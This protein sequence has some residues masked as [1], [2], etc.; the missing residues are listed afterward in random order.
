MDET[1]LIK[2]NKTDL[3]ENTSN[4]DE[5]APSR[6]ASFRIWQKD[7]IKRFIT[8][9][10]VMTIKT[11][12]AFGLIGILISLAPVLIFSLWYVNNMR[13]IMDKIILED[14]GIAQTAEDI[15]YNM[16]LVRRAEKNYLLLKDE[17]YLEENQNKLAEVD[18]LTMKIEELSPSDNEQVRKLSNAAI[19]YRAAFDSLVVRTRTQDIAKYNLQIV[20]LNN[21]TQQLA[22]AKAYAENLLKTLQEKKNG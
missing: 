14:V 4:K 5:I 16:L 7:I 1:N 21:Q 10:A 22:G 9:E 8:L 19:Q 3:S 15:S 18:T 13:N 20:Q 6:I 2:T 17:K 11:K 12:I